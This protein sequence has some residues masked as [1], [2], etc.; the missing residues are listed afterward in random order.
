MVIKNF[1]TLKKCNSFQN[2][3]NTTLKYKKKDFLNLLQ[4]KVSN[5]FSIYVKKKVNFKKFYQNWKIWL[6]WRIEFWN[7]YIYNTFVL[8]ICN[9]IN[10]IVYYNIF[11]KTGI[12]E[13][14]IYLVQFF[15]RTKLWKRKKKEKEKA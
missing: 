13:K 4:E 2:T 9:D 14:N 7:V 15:S 11:S 10:F 1:I 12:K 5:A 8:N 6:N 3:W